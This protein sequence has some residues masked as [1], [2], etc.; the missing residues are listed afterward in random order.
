M[1]FIQQPVL[2]KK[3]LGFSAFRALGSFSLSFR[4]GK[5]ER[6]HQLLSHFQET[7]QRPKEKFK[8]IE[9]STLEEGAVVAESHLLSTI[10]LTFYEHPR[11]LCQPVVTHATPFRTNSSDTI[12]TKTIQLNTNANGAKLLPCPKQSYFRVCRRV[13]MEGV[14]CPAWIHFRTGGCPR[15]LMQIC[16]AGPISMRSE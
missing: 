13:W 9:F 11:S 1:I 10:A 15:P 7:T 16:P 6:W 14:T 4:E 5:V 3:L 12:C 2:H 8:T